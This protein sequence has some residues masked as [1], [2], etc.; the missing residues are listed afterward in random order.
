MKI[1]NDLRIGITSIDDKKIWSNGLH[2]NV[3]HLF[4]ILKDAG[5]NVELI[6]ESA[7]ISEM[8]LWEITFGT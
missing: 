3:Y 4:N 5:Y 7:K 1:S 2:Q 6:C 8:I